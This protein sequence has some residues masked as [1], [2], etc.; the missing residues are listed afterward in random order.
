MNEQIAQRIARDLGLSDLTELLAEQLSGSEL[1]SL[2]LA[3][4]K[5]RVGKIEPSKLMQPSPV[6]RVCDLDARLL[7]H[8]EHTA[9]EIASEYEAIELSPLSPLGAVSVLTGLDQANV[10]STV[11]GFECA[12]D[13]TI[14]LAFESARR[15]KNPVDRKMTTRLCSSHRV[16]RFPLPQNPAYTAHFKLFS[17]VNAGRDAG[18]FSFE[19]AALQEHIGFYLSLLSQL[20]TTGFAFEDIVVELSDTRAVSHLCS[21]FNIDRDEV[22]ALVRAR[23][24]NTTAK[25]I[26]KYSI[27]WPKTLTQPAEELAQYNLPKHNLIQLNTLE[28]NVCARLRAEH[29]NV[30]FEF[31]MHRLTGLGYYEGPCFHIKLKNDRGQAFALADGGFVNWTQLL[32]GDSKERLM[33]SAIGIEL[34]CRMFRR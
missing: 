24:S 11:R 8:L 2:L 13:P 19:V 15:R 5:R 30:K 31:N 33:T 12:S 1:H 32:L 23:D 22:R 10:L 21:T 6:T 34:L 14:G 18:S 7:N 29:T 25:L 9:F 20:A 26:E 17:L 28:Q 27:E 16:V 3:V 4:L